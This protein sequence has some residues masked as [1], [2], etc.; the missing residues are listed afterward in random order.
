M[1]KKAK[2]FTLFQK[3]AIV[4]VV[5]A[6]AGAVF[7]VFRV[8]GGTTANITLAT[9]EALEDGLVA[10][11]TMD[12]EDF[13]GSQATAEV[14]DR[15]GNGNHGNVVFPPNEVADWTTI[16]YDDFEGGADNFT[17]GGADAFLC[18]SCGFAH[19]GNDA[20]DLQDNS[21]NSSAIITTNNQ[22]VSGYSE[23]RVSFW[24]RTEGTSSGHDFFL[25]YSSNGGTD[26]TLVE[27][28]VTGTDH[29]NSEFHNPTVTLDSGTYSFTNQAKIKIRADF[30]G[31]AND[32][33]ID[34]VLWEGEGSASDGSNSGTTTPGRIG[35]AL[36]FDGIDDYVSAGDIDGGAS[37][38]AISFW[39]K[40]AT[41][42]ASHSLVH[43]DYSNGDYITTSS[44][45]TVTAN[46]FTADAIYVDGSSA[47]AVIADLNWHHVVVA[48]PSGLAADDFSIAS[49]TSAVK[50]F[51]GAIDD[52]RVYNRVLSA[53]EITRLYQLGGTA[54]LNTTVSSQPALESGLVG[55][56]TFDGKD[57]SSTTVARTVLDRSGQSNHGTTT[58]NPLATPGRIGQ[59]LSFDGTDDYVNVPDDASLDFGSSEDFSI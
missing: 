18:E 30:A 22:D 27:D 2:P 31:N 34:E 57:I 51:G 43:L 53:D 55:H 14:R 25:E 52:V 29:N 13:D 15:S 11:W 3:L 24:Y 7:V 4:L 17:F 33:Y 42:T 26:W 9:Q 12:G 44:N 32:V 40:A 1:R 8:S 39:M 19:E 37:V 5:V 45:G 59:A 23:M 58:G 54:K 50:P 48:L 36:N 16:T 28:W 6:I 38:R 56:W 46:G 20:A 21:L 47:S 49:T 35:Q 10:H 41:T